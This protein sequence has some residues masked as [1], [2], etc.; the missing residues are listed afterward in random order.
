MTKN[1]A[2]TVIFAILLASCSQ[3][4]NDRQTK[5][6]DNQTEKQR[7]MEEK[8][9]K[10]DINLPPGSTL[11]DQ[12]SGFSLLDM[13]GGDSSKDYTVN[14]LLFNVALDKIEFMPLISVDANSGVIVTDWYSLDEGKTRIKI[15]LRVVN[16]ELTNESLTVNLF[17]QIYK[18]DK[19]VDQG[20]NDLQ[21]NKIKESILS[22]ARN[23]K[24]AS[25]L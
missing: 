12:D 8:L 5:K 6:T 14:S 13:I 15:N 20:M 4:L 1:L 11:L 19:W 9:E 16:Q 2:F 17:Q 25:E 21:A 22:T 23:L 24:I 10:R 18:E 3:S 7:V